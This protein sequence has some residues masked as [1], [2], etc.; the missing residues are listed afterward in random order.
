MGTL[1]ALETAGVESHRERNDGT[2]PPQLTLQAQKDDTVRQLSLLSFYRLCELTGMPQKLANHRSCGP[3]RLASAI[4]TVRNAREQSFR[5]VLSMCLDR[6]QRQKLYRRLQANDKSPN[7]D[8]SR[9]AEV[10]LMHDRS[11][12]GRIADVIRQKVVSVLKK[13]PPLPSDIGAIETLVDKVLSDL[14]ENIVPREIIDCLNRSAHGHFQEVPDVP[15]PLPCR[16]GGRNGNR[17]GKGDTGSHHPGNGHGTMS[18]A[19]KEVTVAGA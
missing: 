11:R 3:E 16:N 14:P 13:I 12:L 19:P 5:K 6:R 1:S 10:C 9:Y 17:N 2:P 15:A 8:H 4:C 18:H 7:K